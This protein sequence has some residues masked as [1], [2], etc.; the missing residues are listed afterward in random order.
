M[1]AKK[2]TKISLKKRDKLIIP[3]FLK[4]KIAYY[5]KIIH[6][7]ILIVQKYKTLDILGASELNTCIKNLEE[8]FNDLNDIEKILNS[9]KKNNNNDLIEQLQEINNELAVVFRTFGTQKISDLIAV[10][11][12]KDFLEDT[13]ISSNL[14][15]TIQKYVHPIG[16]KLMTWSKDHNPTTKNK[17]LA[18]NRIVEDFMIVETAKDF[19]CFDLARTSRSFQ[20]KVYGIKIALHNVSKKKTLII[21]GVVDDILLQCLN[22]QYLKDKM[23][24]LQAEKPKTPIFSDKNFDSFIQSLTIKE[25]LIY[26]NAELFQKFTVYITQAQLIKEK[27]ISQIVKEF[28]NGELYAQRTTLIQLLIRKND[29]EFQYLAYLLYDLLSN[30]T[31]TGSIDTVEQTILFDSLPWS[32]KSDFRD[33]MKTTIKYTKDLSNYDNNNIPIE[34][35]ICLMKAS[36]SVKEKAMTKLKEVKAKTED[37][38]SKARQYLNGLLKIPFGIY[39]TE[40]ILK[41]IKN[42]QT[43]FLD[44]M[45]ILRSEKILKDIPIKNQYTSVEIFKYRERIQKNYISKI[46]ESYI[47]KLKQ[48][49]CRGKR[50]ILIIN[51][52]HINNVVKKYSLKGRKICH[53]G[54]RTSFMK[55]KMEEFIINYQ[56][57]KEITNDLYNN[58]T[59]Q[60]GMKIVENSTEKIN[61]INKDSKNI[62]VDIKNIQTILNK[63]I[64]G[65]DNAKRQIER[66]IGQWI[67]GEQTGYSF[68]FEGPPGVGKTSLAKNGLANCLKDENNVSRPFALIAMG[69]SSNASTLAGHNYTYVGSTWGRIVDILIE[70]KCMNPIIFIDEL[71]KVSKTEHGKEIIG[72]LTHLID[73]TQNENFQ[74]KYFSGIDLDLSRAL[75]IFSYNDPHAIDKVLLDRI[76][77]VKF[78]SLSLDEKIV[79]TNKYILPEIYKK[80][81]LKDMIIIDDTI[82]KYIIQIYTNEAGVRKL[83][84]ILFEIISEINL[85]ILLKQDADF[86]I[87]LHVDI[88][89]VKTKYLK[90]HQQVRYKE[91]HITPLIGTING[92]WANSMGLGGIIPIQCTWFPTSSFLEFKLTGLQGDIMKESMNV[93]KTLAWNLTDP[94]TQKQIIIKY[95]QHLTRMNYGIHVHCPEGGTPKDGPSAGTAITVAI[96]SL[97]NNKKIKNNIAITGEMNLQGEVTAIGGLDCKINGGIR[98]GITEFIFPKQNKNDFN[99]FLEKYGEKE[100]IKSTVFHQV[101]DIKEVLD[102]VFVK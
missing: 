96:F 6:R 19:D 66:I 35:Q 72:I 20:T 30:E 90:N 60:V 28:L 81:G 25:L 12:G 22:D 49:Y 13:K 54:K 34:Q 53:S 42:I 92:L 44:L 38:G 45:T 100:K 86:E 2:N 95:K 33:A 52:C 56:D 94:E 91:I 88:E 84:E 63:S 4:Q 61:N 70:K 40:P 101:S 62:T 102:L 21:C 98:G 76:H 7:T 99:K 75:F 10:I 50:E 37:S 97:L 74:D 23:K 83:K 77:R 47:S 5:H 82:I 78:D 80:I 3:T 93:A 67:N 32:V 17:K 51:I 64:H 71:D 29:P 68:G 73:S 31:G 41:R 43:N 87:P 36:D 79:I 8:I 18:K 57:N 11:F 9:N 89:D 85:E 26:S 58:F 46:K 69:G 39:K 65:H 48:L 15:N 55:K 16:Y 59:D 1:K 27:T 24:S 14:Q